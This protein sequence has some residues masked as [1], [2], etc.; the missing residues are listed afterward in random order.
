M[1][2]YLFRKSQRLRGNS[3]FRAVLSHKCF[4]SK[5]LIRLYIAE[6]NDLGARLGISIGRDVGSAI[7]RN[8][9]KRYVREVFRQEQYN[10]PANYDYLLIFSGKMS[11]KS[12]SDAASFVEEMGFESIREVFL[13]LV[14]QAVEKAKKAQ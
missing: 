9:L 13:E 5:D 10:I 4:V 7:V 14:R 11:K 8:R 1:K 2:R 3:D 12:K 6:N